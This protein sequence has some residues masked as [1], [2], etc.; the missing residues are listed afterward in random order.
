MI[1]WI[2]NFFYTNF[3]VE[4]VLKNSKFHKNCIIILTQTLKKKFKITIFEIF[5]LF[6]VNCMIMVTLKSH[7]F[8]F[9]Y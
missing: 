3:N 9:K 2:D 8:F 7:N 4:N 1:G 6:I 5:S